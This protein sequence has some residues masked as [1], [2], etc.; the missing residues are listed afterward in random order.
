VSKKPD[1]TD[2]LKLKSGV[3]GTSASP[4]GLINGTT[5]YWRVRAVADEGTS[6]FSD[7]WS[8][9]VGT[10]VSAGGPEGMEVRDFAL[11]ECFPNP[12]NPQTTISYDVPTR[13]RVLIAIYNPLGQL[14]A[15][16]VNG[17]VAQGHHQVHFEGG[18]HTSGVYFCRMEAIG[19]GG[20]PGERFSQ[21]KRIMLLK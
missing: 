12:F 5:Y 3:T 11:M 4:S 14:I 1:F 15:T 19:L 9:T 16:L 18:G 7:P 8:F 21:T 17:E 13:S 2:T 20:E 10:P 6:R